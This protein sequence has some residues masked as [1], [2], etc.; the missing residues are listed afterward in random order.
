[1]PH[2][3]TVTVRAHYFL[4]ARFW[5]TPIVSRAQHRAALD[6]LQ[7]DYE[8]RVDT[9][10]GIMGTGLGEDPT[11]GRCN[12]RSRALEIAEEISGERVVYSYFKIP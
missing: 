1:M 8:R 7:R 6:H 5:S 9:R 2:C 12:F 3:R 11:N 4:S 10:F